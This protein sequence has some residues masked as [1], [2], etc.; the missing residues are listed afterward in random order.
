MTIAIFGNTFRPTVLNIMEIILRF[1]STKKDTLLLDKE[2]FTYYQQHSGVHSGY[3]HLIAD[4]NF[5]ADIALSIGGD[6]TFLSTAARIGSK[7]IPIM[8]VNTGRLGF[9]AD[10]SVDEVEKALDA[11]LHN[12]INVEERTLLKVDFSDGR[13]I[14]YPY[15][16]NEVSVL[17]Q[18]SS[19]MISINTYLNEEAIHSYHADGL[20]VATPTGSTAYS[21]SVGGPLMVPQAQNIILSPIASHSLTVR[22]LVVPDDWII[23]L[24]VHS[25]NGC[26]LVTMDGRTLVLEENV[27]IRISKAEY[28]IRVAKQLNHT[29]FDSL[30]S[31]LM[32]G[33]DKRN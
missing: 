21:M 32:W 4:D 27:K 22:P 2:L 23:D 1:F 5:T 6:G 19:S 28:R 24:E 11:I 13:V 25:R 9:L 12:Q 33:L 18:D 30:K 15:V 17:K 10:V 20:I 16:L 8:G 14:D 29:F 26:Y 3:Q 7:N 31:K